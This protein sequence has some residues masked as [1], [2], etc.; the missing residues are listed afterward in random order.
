MRQGIIIGISNE[1]GTAEPLTGVLAYDQAREQLR[2]LAGEPSP[3]DR[4]EIWTRSGLAK[5]AKPTHRLEGDGAVPAAEEE[6]VD[7]PRRRKRS[8]KKAASAPAQD[9]EATATKSDNT[10]SES[11]Q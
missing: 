7:A 2:E 10:P 9:A 3:Y 8:T 5:A 11:P 4:L 1:A 6:T